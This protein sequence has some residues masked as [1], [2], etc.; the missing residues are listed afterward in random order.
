MLQLGRFACN[1]C[2]ASV[3][4]AA[5]NRKKV[6]PQNNKMQSN[7]SSYKFDTEHNQSKQQTSHLDRLGFKTH[8][9]VKTCNKH[10]T[11]TTWYVTDKECT[12]ISSHT[13]NTSQGKEGWSTGKLVF[14]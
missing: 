5:N 10:V 6:K 2:F 1:T 9:K 14:G 7:K 4:P 13:L 11:L 8:S 12:P 3:V